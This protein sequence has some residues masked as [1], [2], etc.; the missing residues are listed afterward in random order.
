MRPPDSKIT[1]YQSYT[2]PQIAVDT[3]QFV[4]FKSNLALNIRFDSQ[5]P[6]I[7]SFQSF[8]YIENQKK[9]RKKIRLSNAQLVCGKLITVCVWALSTFVATG[10]GFIWLKKNTHKHHFCGNWSSRNIIVETSSP[11][12]IGSRC[13]F[14]EEKVSQTRLAFDRWP[15]MSGVARD[16]QCAL[17]FFRSQ[18][19]GR[20]YSQ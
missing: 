18:D 4:L 11:P 2:L 14:A 12:A 10:W 9:N 20:R 3:E 5:L 1:A 13:E 8:F 16:I 7:Y 19:C 15:M 17:C 6:S